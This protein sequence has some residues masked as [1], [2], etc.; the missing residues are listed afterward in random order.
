M[1]LAETRKLL[2]SVNRVSWNHLFLRLIGQ[3]ISQRTNALVTTANGATKTATPR[4]AALNRRTSR[5][6]QGSDEVTVAKKPFH[7]RR[8]KSQRV[9]RQSQSVADDANFKYDSLPTISFTRAAQMRTRRLAITLGCFSIKATSLTHWL[10][11]QSGAQDL[12]ATTRTEAD[13]NRNTAAA[14]SYR[15]HQWAGQCQA[16]HRVFS[17][18]LGHRRTAAL[19]RRLFLRRTRDLPLR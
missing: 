18:G 5:P 2:N 7:L 16:A 10:Q 8:S 3:P 14:G 1:F 19:R 12:P 11:V 4:L 17:Q 6:S 9:D 13:A 15:L